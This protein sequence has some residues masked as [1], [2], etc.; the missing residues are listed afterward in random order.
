MA[1]QFKKTELM[2]TQRF[3]VFT[4]FRLPP[5]LLRDV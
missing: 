1:S 3:G 2:G 4:S 5:S